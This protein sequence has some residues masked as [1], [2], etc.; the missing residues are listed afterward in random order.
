MTLTKLALDDVRHSID[1]RAAMDAL[2]AGHKVQSFT[3]PEPEP[4]PEHLVEAVYHPDTRKIST[5]DLVG[6]NFVG[7]MAREE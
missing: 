3:P 4:E 1:L 5:G 2:L 6:L 7:P